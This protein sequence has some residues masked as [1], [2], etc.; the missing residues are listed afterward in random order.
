MEFQICSLCVV[1]T[2]RDRDVCASN[3]EPQNKNVQVKNKKAQNGK[4][5]SPGTPRPK[6][7]KMRDGKGAG[8][9]AATISG[10]GR[11]FAESRPELPQKPRTPPE[12]VAATDPVRG[13]AAVVIANVIARILARIGSGP[14]L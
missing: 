6:K 10:G 8:R 5:K 4:A 3:A 9:V 7:K 1:Q 12:T 14:R 13:V 11:G 2:P